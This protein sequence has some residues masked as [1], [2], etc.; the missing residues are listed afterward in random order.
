LIL[1]DPVDYRDFAS[2]AAI[3]LLYSKR[4]YWELRSFLEI[5]T[6]AKGSEFHEPISP[7]ELDSG[8][9]LGLED[10]AEA[11]VRTPADIAPL[12]IVNDDHIPVVSHSEILNEKIHNIIANSNEPVCCLDISRVLRFERTQPVLPIIGCVPNRRSDLYI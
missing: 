6:P 10:N 4:A 3:L 11:S 9:Q 8:A 2:S 1:S 12:R 5:V 7:S